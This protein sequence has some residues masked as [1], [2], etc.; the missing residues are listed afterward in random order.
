MDKFCIK[1]FYLNQISNKLLNEDF[2]HFDNDVLIYKPFS[3]VK[4]YLIMRS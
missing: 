1:S 4:K 3:E 2:V